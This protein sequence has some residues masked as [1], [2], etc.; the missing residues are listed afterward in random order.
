MAVAAASLLTALLV[1]SA[2]LLGAVL[3][4]GCA[5][6]SRLLLP[7][8]ARAAWPVSDDHCTFYEGH[9]RLPPAQTRSHAMRIICSAATT[10]VWV[11]LD[12]GSSSR[13]TQ[14][15]CRIA[16]YTVPSQVHLRVS[17]WAL[18]EPT[19]TCI[20]MATRARGGCMPSQV[21]HVR[22]KPAHHEFRYAVRYVLVQLDRPPPW[23]HIHQVCLSTP[24]HLHLPSPASAFTLPSVTHC[25]AVVVASHAK[26]W[27]H[28]AAQGERHMTAAAARETAGTSGRVELLTLPPSA[29]SVRRGSVLT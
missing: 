1:N 17:T 28:D 15:A 3:T 2:R 8:A 20:H 10:L 19:R 16:A 14:C 24:S 12:L 29:G 25:V 5:A 23:F 21:H 7:T 22:R 11:G 9:V 18:P 27:K 4:L 26:R 6:V 13:F